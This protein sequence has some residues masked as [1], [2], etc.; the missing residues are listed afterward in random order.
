MAMG[1]AASQ[2]RFLEL[3][4]R[5]S[6]VEYQAQRIC[7]ERSQL[8]DKQTAASQKYNEAMSNRKIVYSFNSG[9]DIKSVDI[10]Y[11]N[12]SNYMNQQLDGLQSTQQ[13]LFLVS[14]SGNKIIVSSEDEIQKMIDSNLDQDGNKKFDYS[15]FMV[16]PDL[17]NVENFQKA[18]QDGVYY[19]ATYN[20]TEEESDT[21]FKTFEWDEL[22]GGAIS[23][24]YDKTDDAAAQ[25]EYDTTTSE[26]Q[27][28]DKKLELELNRLN[29]ERE[30]IVTE[31]E[32]VQKVIKD[33][34]ESTFKAFS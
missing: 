20:S 16:A 6:D 26:I 29:T 31:M 21:K 2:A 27:S 32:S 4:A 15:D 1:L 3:T 13:Q 7:F 24:E 10:T 11:K 19:F 22:G 8:A 23:E 14:S 12:Y 18:I 34:T 25:S 30:E 33:N 9:E 17:D 28:K 5:K